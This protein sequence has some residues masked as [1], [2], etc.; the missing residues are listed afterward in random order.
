M[1]RGRLCII[2]ENVVRDAETNNISVINIIE[3]LHAQ[4]FPLFAPKV[5]FFVLWERELTDPP[6]YHSEVIVTI[7]EQRLHTG[8][9]EIDFREGRRHRSIITILGLVIPQ[10]GQLTFSL[11]VQDGI[12]ATCTIPIIAPQS[13]IRSE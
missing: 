7:N 12:E 6:I 5:V 1:I 13:V 2:A 4:G 8:P 10:P 9:V 3:E 11:R